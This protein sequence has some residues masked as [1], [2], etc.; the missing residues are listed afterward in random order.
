MTK[1]TTESWEAL[2]DGTTPGPWEYREH[3]HCPYADMEDHAAIHGGPMPEIPYPCGCEEGDTCEVQRYVVGTEDGVWAHNPPFWEARPADMKAVAHFP[4]AVAEV[5]RLREEL[6]ALRRACIESAEEAERNA[7]V[8]YIPDP[9]VAVE[10]AERDTADIITRIL[11]G[12][13]S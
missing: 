6:E 11:E 1:R 10:E 7:E 12:S 2:L 9:Y 8:A 5:V 13:E 4:E 3:E